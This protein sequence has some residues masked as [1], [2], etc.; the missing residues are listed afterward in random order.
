MAKEVT[1]YSSSQESGKELLSVLNLTESPQSTHTHTHTHTHTQIPANSRLQPY[2]IP[3][4]ALLITT[5]QLTR[6]SLIPS[7]VV[8]RQHI[9]QNTVIT[10][11]SERHAI[12]IVQRVCQYETSTLPCRPK[13]ELWKVHQH[14][15]LTT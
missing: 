5:K 13:H 14:E 6:R 15:N 10:D 4:I 9:N 3:S 12:L 11:V 2:N 7:N 8:V 1:V